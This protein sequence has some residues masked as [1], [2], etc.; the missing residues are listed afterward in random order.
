MVLAKEAGVDI[1]SFDWVTDRLRMRL[2]VDL[3]ESHAPECDRLPR[4]TRNRLADPFCKA[5]GDASWR[6]LA[7]DPRFMPHHMVVSNADLLLEELTASSRR[8]K[9]EAAW[10]ALPADYKEAIRLFSEEVA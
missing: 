6:R 7:K 4:E 8:G 9:F 3:F 1:R 5:L 10:A 2:F